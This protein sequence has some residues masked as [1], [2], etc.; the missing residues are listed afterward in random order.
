MK[1]G[2][3]LLT[4]LRE[5]LG[6]SRDQQDAREERI[7][8]AQVE[9]TDCFLSTW[10]N[11]L[12]RRELAAR[13]GILEA[14]GLAPFPALFTLDGRLVS[15]DCRRTRYGR[16]FRVGAK[17]VD[18]DV[19]DRTLARKGYRMGEVV[20]PAWA[21]LRGNGTGL[22]ASYWVEVFKAKRNYWTG[23]EAEA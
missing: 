1:H 19:S 13:I 5:R 18:A 9:D 12:T 11:D 17:W 23:E 10:A 4:E 6:R 22:G 3:E 21:V 14:G 16:A 8:S 2:E 20:R 7:A 15:D